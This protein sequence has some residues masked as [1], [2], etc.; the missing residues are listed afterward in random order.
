MKI[1]YLGKG[2]FSTYENYATTKGAS[3][4]VNSF[5][6]PRTEGTDSAS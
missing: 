2:E 1:D 3:Q 5:A 6:G 4:P